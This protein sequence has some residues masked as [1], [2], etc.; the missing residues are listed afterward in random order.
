MGRAFHEASA[1]ARAV[2]EEAS[3]ALGLRRREAL[4]RGARVRAPAHRQH[5][6]RRA[7]RQRGRRRGSSPSAGSRPALVG[8]AQPGRVLG[9]RGRRGRSRFAGCGDRRP[10]PRRVHAGG[11][12]GGHGGDGRDPGR[13]ARRSSR[14]SAATPRRARWSRS[15]TS[16]P[17]GRSSSPAIAAPS[18]ARSRWRPRAGRQASVLLPVS[19]PFHCR[20]W[21]RRP[22]GSPRSSRG[23]RGRRTRGC[24]SSATWT[25]GS[26]READ[27]VRP[28]LIRQVTAPVRWTDCVARLAR[29]GVP[30]VRRG[31][32][33][34][35]AD[36]AA[37][38][39]RR[40][41]DGHLGRGSWPAWTR[42]WPRWARW[43]RATR[44]PPADPRG[45]G[46]HRHRRDARHRARHRGGPCSTTA[47]PW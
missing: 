28:F 10:A 23:V 26:R 47:R 38:A 19:A 1:A 2:F 24:R 30:H 20:S 44:A 11:R 45:P 15:P 22:S 6:A 9:A 37:Q 46:R 12:A 27:D 18:S 35:G 40:R 25:P 29:E 17:R 7:H 14:R 31:G 39:D 36:R 8:R 13:R 3:D 33:G 41:A 42:R 32:A 5:P 16:T 21:R 43:S 34:A 4:L